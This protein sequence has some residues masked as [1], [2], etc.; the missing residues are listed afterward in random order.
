M[1]TRC[2][3]TD[4]NDAAW[5]AGLCREQGQFAKAEPL[6]ERALAIREKALGPKHPRVATSLSGLATLYNNQNK[7]RPSPFTTGR[8]RFGKKPWVR[9]T[10]TWLVAS[11][12]TRACY[13]TWAGRRKPSRWKLGRG[14]FG[15]RASD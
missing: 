4:L 3:D 5:V 8:W 2:Y 7:R 14:Q 10:Q 6:Y 15:L 1:S 9:S 11:E 12:T 13:E